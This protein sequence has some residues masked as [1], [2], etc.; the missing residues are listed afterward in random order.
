MAEIRELLDQLNAERA[1]VEAERGA[2]PF[3]RF[4]MP[5]TE[6]DP[7]IYHQLEDWG[8]D[9]TIAMAWTVDDPAFHSLEAKLEAMER[10]ADRFITPR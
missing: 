2:E 4:V 1:I 3:G 8:I 5:Q 7:G 9:G 6:P 10:F